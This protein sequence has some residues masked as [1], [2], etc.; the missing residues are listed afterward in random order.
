MAYDGLMALPERLH[1]HVVVLFP[2]V[3][4][5]AAR[6]DVIFVLISLAVKIIAIA[7]HSWIE[8]ICLYNH[9]PVHLRRIR[10][11]QGLPLLQ[12]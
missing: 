4:L 12:F 9:Y 2:V 8:E 1:E 11:L 3:P 5:M 10:K 7:V 6:G